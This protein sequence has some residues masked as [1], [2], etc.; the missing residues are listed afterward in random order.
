MKKDL[1]FKERKMIRTV[2]KNLADEDLLNVFEI[3]KFA[4]VDGELFDYMA[5]KLDISDKEMQ[6]LRDKVN[7]VLN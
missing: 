5:D 4:L 7:I 6:E 1:T 2:G 3:A